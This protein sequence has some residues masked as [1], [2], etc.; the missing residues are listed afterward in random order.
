[1]LCAGQGHSELRL[2]TASA[3]RHSGQ[4]YTAEYSGDEVVGVKPVPTA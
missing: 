2:F 1:M 4:K 3:E